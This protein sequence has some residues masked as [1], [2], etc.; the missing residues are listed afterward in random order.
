MAAHEDQPIWDM[1]LSPHANLLT[2]GSDLSVALWRAPGPDDDTR[3]DASRF[4]LGRFRNQGNMGHFLT[5]TS[6]TWLPNSNKFAVS[7]RE[8]K[9][10]VFD[11][12]TG[13][14]VQ[15]LFIGDQNVG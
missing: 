11:G 15:E 2:V 3:K 13:K 8:Q 7:Y 10:V 14:E 6:A 5:P 1:S 4:L 9:V 12:E